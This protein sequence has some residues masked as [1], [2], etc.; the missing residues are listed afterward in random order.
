MTR[1]LY[2]HHE[3][4]LGGAPL[5]LLYLIK[6]LDRSKYEPRVI[7][8]R[9]GPAAELYRK[10][11]LKVAI[12]NGPDLSHTE[13]VWYRWSRFPMLLLRLLRSIPL[14]FR[15]RRKIAEWTA[16]SQETIVHLNSSTL[17]TGAFAAHSLGLPVVWHIREPLASGYLGVRRALLQ[18]SIKRL[19]RKVIA[20]S[21]HDARQLGN[22]PALRQ[23]LEI[24]HNFVDFHHFDH[25]LPCGPIH[26]ELEIP[27]N[28]PMILFLGGST[29]VKGFEILVKA[30]PAILGGSRHLHV[31]IAGEVEPE[32]EARVCDLL[33]DDELKKRIHF[34]GS[35]Q[36][37]P[38]LLADS[39]ILLFPSTVPHFAR[40]VIEAAAMAK[41]SIASDLG[42]VRELIVSNE[43]GI[44]VPA[45]DARALARAVIELL[46]DEPRAYR[47][48]M[49]GLSLARDRF[50]ARKNAK[51]TCKVYQDM[52]GHP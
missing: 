12:V 48:G 7:C 31:L 29:R 15:L 8:L 16:Q 26:R 11:G 6:A 24:I 10:E 33:R 18:L 25:R 17:V 46:K 35:R 36:D 40:P 20:I 13:L 47:L 27:I 5:S 1:V 50:D 32:V 45:G 52:V 43:T 19:A 51:A 38:Q 42:G 14:F 4:A 44:L 9:D 39:R 28:C 30:L 34:L 37:I 23:K 3:R 2:I 41:P 49:Q 21:E 22:S